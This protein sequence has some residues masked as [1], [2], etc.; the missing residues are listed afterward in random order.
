[1]EGIVEELV[2]EEEAA[3]VWVGWVA[4]GEQVD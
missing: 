2:D 4:T 1:M 3:V